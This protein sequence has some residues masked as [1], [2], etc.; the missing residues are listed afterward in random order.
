MEGE[1][2]KVKMIKGN[3]KVYTVIGNPV[4]HSKSPDMHNAALTELQINA[5]YVAL[6][7][8]VDEIESICHLIKSGTISGSNVTIPYKEEVMKYVDVL[9]EEANMIGSVNTLYPKDGKLIGDNTDG[10]GFEKSLFADNGFVPKNKNCLV[11]GAGGASKAVTTK[12]CQ[13]G[14]KSLLIYDID[15]KKAEELLSHL[16]KFNYETSISLASSEDID[17]YSSDSNL[18]I[19]CTPIGMKED[20]PVLISSESISSNHFVYD[21]I[22]TPPETKLLKSA[23]ENGAKVING[24]DMLA[25]QGAESLSIWEDVPPPYEI[26]KK[27][28]QNG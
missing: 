9:T 18:I 23:R 7:V 17:Q 28:L 13:N 26:M 12:L 25:Y 10:L 6:E 2:L 24:M 20:D 1:Y 21:I 5:C 4:K 3:T 19:N 22:Y 27:E 11:L 15:Q 8:K 16:E 14:I